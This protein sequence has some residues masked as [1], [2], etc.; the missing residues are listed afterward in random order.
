MHIP[1]TVL[2][3]EILAVFQQLANR[4]RITERAGD[5]AHVSRLAK[6][7]FTAGPYQCCNRMP[8]RQQRIDQVSTDESRSTYDCY[9]HDT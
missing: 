1:V 6:F 9:M 5:R 2:A 3:Q 4:C 8:C 7:A